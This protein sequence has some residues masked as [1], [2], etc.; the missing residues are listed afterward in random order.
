M[1]NDRGFFTR[2][3]RGEIE[4]SAAKGTKEIKGDNNQV[5]AVIV[6]GQE[7]DEGSDIT[8]NFRRA[9]LIV[10]VSDIQSSADE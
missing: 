6:R 8:G 2:F 3:E 9:A 10:K 5:Y 4:M 7:F 1:K